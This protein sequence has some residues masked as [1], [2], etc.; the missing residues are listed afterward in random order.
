MTI[1]IELLANI[2]TSI[3]GMH[4]IS[5]YCQ[6]LYNGIKRIICMIIGILAYFITVTTI[7]NITSFEGVFGF[8]YL[9][10]MFFYARSC[11][12]GNIIEHAIGTMIWACIVLFSTIPVLELLAIITVNNTSQ[13][14]NTNHYLR[15]EMLTAITILKFLLCQSMLLR[16]RTKSLYLNKNDG[17]VLIGICFLILLIIIGFFTMEINADNKVI[18]HVLSM[19]LL[20]GAVIIILLTFV[21]FQKLSIY[22]I[23][24]FTKEYNN[25]A[26]GKQGEYVKYIEQL[27]KE[28]QIMRHDSS[29]HYATLY[30]FLKAGKYEEAIMYLGELEENIRK[31]DELP[32]ITNNDNL[33]AILHK[34]YNDCKEKN[35][36]FYCL[37][38]AQINR[39]KSSDLGVLL[40]NLLNNAIEA[41]YLS[42][43]KEISLEIG[44]YQG[45]LYCKICNTVR[46]SVLENNPELITNKQNK[47][48]H[49]FGMKSIHQIAEKYD[50]YYEHWDSEGEF[51]QIIYLKYPA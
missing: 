22:Y 34:T 28:L 27:N 15:A 12:K 32:A 45:Y 48:F 13:L 18:R 51:I 4:F 44:N 33:N 24:D 40:Y 16:K 3:I 41:T 6:P 47:E 21:V 35:I 20:F 9:F 11:C 50:G 43:R 25:K 36:V 39:I 37:I 10:V 29:G 26:V 5:Q 23:N 49:G 30:M 14:I 8:A 46:E 42:D 19:M 38:H 7:N 1:G 17:Y 31:Y 2:A